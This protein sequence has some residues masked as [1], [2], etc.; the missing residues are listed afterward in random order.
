MYFFLVKIHCFSISV[1]D[2]DVGCRNS[3]VKKGFRINK[4]VCDRMVTKPECF[5]IPIA[6]CRV[7]KTA[8]CKMVPRQ[9]CQDT[10]SNSPYCQQ[11]ESFRNGP[12]FGSCS[13]TTCGNYFPKDQEILT[14]SS[15]NSGVVSTE[16]VVEGQ[17]DGDIYGNL[18]S[19]DYGNSKYIIY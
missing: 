2:G 3:T 16:E 18:P 8:N 14:P 6:D 7:G 17:S 15:W 4:V 1:P 5:N 19:P 13:S 11:C 12:G 10:C 9:V